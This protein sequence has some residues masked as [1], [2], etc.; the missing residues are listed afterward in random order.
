VTEHVHKRKRF[1]SFVDPGGEKVERCACGAYR[2]SAGKW[3]RPWWV[4]RGCLLEDYSACP[5]DSCL[6]ISLCP[7]CGRDTL[8]YWSENN[9]MYVCECGVAILRRDVPRLGSLHS[10]VD[11]IIAAQDTVGRGRR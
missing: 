4:S 3:R 2:V 9:E 7:E 10:S 6:A 11:D 5:C 1:G 8:C